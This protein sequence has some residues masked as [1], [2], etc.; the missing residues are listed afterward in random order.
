MIPGTR[1]GG[2]WWGTPQWDSSLWAQQVWDSLVSYPWDRKPLGDSVLL[3]G[4]KGTWTDRL[5]LSSGQHGGVLVAA[6]P[7][8]RRLSWMA[9]QGLGECQAAESYVHILHSLRSPP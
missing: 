9:G 2:Q 1:V 8:P 5:S 6:M 7:M 4:K 3:N